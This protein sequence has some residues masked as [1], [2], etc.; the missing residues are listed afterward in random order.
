LTLLLPFDQPTGRHPDRTVHFIPIQFIYMAEEESN[1]DRGNPIKALFLDLVGYENGL[2]I[3][4]VDLYRNPLG[5]IE[6]NC[7]D[8]KKYISGNR[9]MLTVIG[10]WIVVNSIIID[11]NSAFS[12]YLHGKWNLLGSGKP[13]DENMVNRISSVMADVMDK[14]MA[15]IAVVYVALGT[16]IANRFCRNLNFSLKNHLEVMTYSTSM[17]FMV[18]TVFSGVF[19]ING[20]VAEGL[21]ILAGI[22]SWTGYKDYLELVRTRNYFK[23][24]GVEIERNY[25]I[26]KGLASVILVIVSLAVI[27]GFQSMP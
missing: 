11:W 15:P 5:V 18:M 16:L 12:R 22:I 27:I 10:L 9:L 24:H 8:D 3:T 4:I 21:L 14:Y 20:L 7:R 13:I 6:S 23:E 17:Y 19:A 25:K 1:K 2:M 26:A